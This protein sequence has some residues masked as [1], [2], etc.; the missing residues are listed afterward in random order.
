MNNSFESEL[1]KRDKVVIIYH[2]IDEIPCVDVLYRDIMYQFMRDTFNRDSVREQ[3]LSGNHR[4][5]GYNI[6]T[7]KLIN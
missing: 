3:I 2:T 4:F 5:S 7:G 1:K 6:I